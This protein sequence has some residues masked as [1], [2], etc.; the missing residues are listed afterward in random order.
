MHVIPHDVHRASRRLL[1]LG[2]LPD[3]DFHIPDGLGQHS[4]SGYRN[5]HGEDEWIRP[6]DVRL[7]L[8]IPFSS[9][10]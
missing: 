4:G 7:K 5:S 3:C 9:S 2:E 6:R 10:S 8:T 1:A